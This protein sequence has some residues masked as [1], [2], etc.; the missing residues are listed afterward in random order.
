MRTHLERVLIS[1]FI[2]K[3][4]IVVISNSSMAVGESLL[5]FPALVMGVIIG[6][7]ELFLVHRD[8]GGGTSLWVTHGWH[9]FTSGIVFT[10]ISMN[11]DFFLN[12]TGLINSTIPLLNNPIAIRV[13][14][15]LIIT[16]KIHTVAGLK[17]YGVG[18]RMGERW[19]HCL[20]ISALIVG[21]P[22]IYP[23]LQPTCASYVGEFLCPPV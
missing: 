20:L 12:I 3:I 6:V 11:V 19:G 18:T 8:E 23:Y 9:A 22:Y 10:F 5:I 15:A 7:Y 16:I 14:L 21:S 2:S 4:Y 1:F 17:G 13:I